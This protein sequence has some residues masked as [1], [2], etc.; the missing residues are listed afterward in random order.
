[1]KKYL[2]TVAVALVILFILSICAWVWLTGQRLP[3][4]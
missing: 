2:P 3:A 1:M 4:A